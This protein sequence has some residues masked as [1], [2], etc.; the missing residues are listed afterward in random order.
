MAKTEMI[1]ARLEPALKKNSEAVLAKLGL[2]TSEAI[3]MFLSQV[4]LHRG[5]PFPA[6]IP[7]AATRKALKE[8]KARQGLEPVEDFRAWLDSTR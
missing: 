1:N 7:N 6:R 4:V 3:T 8:A 5:L 2:S